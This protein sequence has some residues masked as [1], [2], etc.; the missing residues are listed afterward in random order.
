MNICRDKIDK[1]ILELIIEINNLSDFQKKILQNR[2]I[3]QVKLYIKKSNRYGFL[4]Y[5]LNLII[6][7]GSIFLPALL[8]IQNNETYKEQIYWLTWVV[9]LIITISNGI[10][11]LY[12]INTLYIVYNQVK[13][14]LIT[15]G[16]RYLQLSGKY[17]N[18]N[19][20][21]AFKE[22]C[23]K[24]EELKMKQVQK[25]L[26]DVGNDQNDDDT[27]LSSTNS[28]SNNST[29]IEEP[30]IDINNLN[31]ERKNNIETNL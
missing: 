14:K 11:Q 15:E 19:H 10:I 12:S 22:F 20:N 18:K 13:E 8:A 28:I 16:W 29:P 27:F 1:Q 3:N 2:Y 25:E 5:T 4:Y 30:I 6:T 23:L 7:I 31:N 24:I 21:S 26:E 9:S 17:K